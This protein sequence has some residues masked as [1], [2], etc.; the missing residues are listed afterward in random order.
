MRKLYIL[1][2]T[3]LIAIPGFLAAQSTIEIRIGQNGAL[4]YSPK[5]AVCN[6]GDTVKFIWYSGNHPTRS[7]DGSSIPQFNLNSSNPVKTFVFNTPGVIPFY[8]VGHG[9]AGGS[10]MSGSITVNAALTGF[11]A[12][13]LSNSLSVFPNPATEKLNVNFVVKKDNMVVVKMMDVLGNDVAIL[14]SE[15]LPTGEYKYSLPIPSRVNKG[16]YFVK[17]S[18]GTEAAIKRISVQ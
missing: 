13:N 7:D 8:S 17:V 18:V 3:L 11:A 14:F 16:L 12:K 6:V 9:Q 1:I 15:K 10:G 5:N 4:S 2:L